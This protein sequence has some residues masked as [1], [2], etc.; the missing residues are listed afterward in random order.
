MI[1]I[2][3]ALTCSFLGALVIVI[4]KQLSC[5]IPPFM[6]TL[7][8]F[9]IASICMIPFLFLKKEIQ[10]VKLADLP[11]LFLLGITQVTFYNALFVK[12]LETSS[13]ASIAILS[14]LNPILTAIGAI[15]F[16]RQRPNAYQILAFILSFIGA[17]FVI[18]RGNFGTIQD[19]YNRGSLYMLGALICQ[20]IYT[21]TITKISDRYPPLFLTFLAL[22]MG[23]MCTI[24]FIECSFFD[25]ATH[26][27]LSSWAGILII[28]CM[29]TA[30][31]FYLYI[32]ALKH[33]GASYTTLITFS[34]IPLFAFIMAYLFL[35][36][37][38]TL[39]Q[40]AGSLLVIGALAIDIRR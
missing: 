40:I 36:E 32:I 8:R 6:F 38:I 10:K 2:V 33:L 39:W 26:I 18:T 37:S 11:V 29:G 3:I 13:A 19:S 35:G 23:V 12:A 16:F 27:S 14:A 17:I 28:S 15:F 34:T 5:T 25:V 21:I 31:A 1:Y 24:P 30:L 7:I 4:T 22:T 9:G 20:V